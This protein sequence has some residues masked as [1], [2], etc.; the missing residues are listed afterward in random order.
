MAT[1]LPGESLDDFA[2]RITEAA[3]TE[4]RLEMIQMQGQFT[5]AMDS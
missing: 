4:L 5:E 3:A 1:L 2:K